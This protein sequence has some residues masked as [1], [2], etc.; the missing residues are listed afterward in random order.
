MPPDAR[1]VRGLH[2][3]MDAP[4]IG[5]RQVVPP[6]PPH[7]ATRPVVRSHH[8]PVNDRPGSGGQ[9]TSFVHSVNPMCRNLFLSLLLV[10]ACRSI[11]AQPP[12]R[13]AC[14]RYEPDTVRVTGKLER[15][16]FYGA[17]GF[18]DD[19]AHDAKEPGFYLELVTPVCA[20]GGD[21]PQLNG[22]R[23]GV[24]LVQLVLDAAG[25]SRLR[26]YLGQHVTLRG[27]LFAEHTGHHHAPLLLEVSSP[28]LVRRTPRKP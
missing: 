23:R 22:P 17:P 27:T 8:H 21:Y 10:A 6:G 3:V 20:E 2:P 13:A 24:R 9:T 25:Y 26:P 28:V 14:L 12:A 5:M 7:R 15:R 1:L 16:I 11:D 19:P 4:C 18:G